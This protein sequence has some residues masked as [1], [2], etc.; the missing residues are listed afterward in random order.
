MPTILDIVNL[1]HPLEL[2]SQPVDGRILEVLSGADAAFTGLQIHALLG[3]GSASG[4]QL[5]L[6]RLRRQGVVTAQPAGRAIL[7]RL[8]ADHLATDYVRGLAHLRHELL[9]RLRSEFESWDPPPLA[10]YLFGSTARR[11]STADSD[12]DICLVRPKEIDDPDRPAWRNRVD[13]L[14]QTVTAWTG[15]D[16]R[17]V[18]FGEDE[19]RF[20]GGH[21]ALLASI[22]DEGILLVGDESVLRRGQA[23]K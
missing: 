14:P 16:T 19:V 7:Y 13:A 5:G 3:T 20:G 10:A 6:N 1:S 9:R 8:N 23:D 4:V 18:E 22:R 21:D 17:L 15:N 12:V 2:I 11:D